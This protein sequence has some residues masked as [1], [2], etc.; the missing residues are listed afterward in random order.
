MQLN[1]WTGLFL[2]TLC[3]P[4]QVSNAS[5][6]KKLL[7]RRRSHS[8][9]EPFIVSFRVRIKGGV[10]NKQIAE[11]LSDLINTEGSDPARV[12]ALSVARVPNATFPPVEWPTTTAPPSLQYWRPSNSAWVNRTKE[13][14]STMWL[15]RRAYNMAVSN[16]AY[17]DDLQAK[18]RR[19]GLAH[20]KALSL[21]NPQHPGPPP[22]R[23]LG[24]VPTVGKL[25]YE[26]MVNTPLPMTTTL[27]PISTAVPPWEMAFTQV[28][29]VTPGPGQDFAA[30]LP[31]G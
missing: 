23:N 13:A 4:L 31:Q 1:T 26:A 8:K 20:A 6:S 11:K 2:A 7:L 21:K 15:A 27:Q 22:V 17:L 9:Q 5:S 12:V 29:T 30:Y 18:L 19:A 10:D 24:E 28:P 3:V 16:Q 25:V 14:E